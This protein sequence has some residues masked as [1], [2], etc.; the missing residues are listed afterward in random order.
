[1]ARH[2]AERLG[3]NP[4]L[5]AVVGGDFNVGETDLAKS[6]TD[7]ADDRTDGYDDTHAL[8]AGGL[9]DGLRLRSLTREMG[10]TYCDTRGD[11]VFPYPGVGA[12][13]VLYVGGAE[14]E[15]FGEASRGRDTFGSDRYPVWA[16]R[17]P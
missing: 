3:E 17:A 6:G 15:R 11:G 2:V 9:V 12:I 16:E 14:A 5:T 4:N 7:P 1:M 8:L 13:D 10:N